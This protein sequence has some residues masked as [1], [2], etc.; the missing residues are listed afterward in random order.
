[1][2]MVAPKREPAA[3]VAIAHGDPLRSRPASM[4]GLASALLKS[5]EALPSGRFVFHRSGDGTLSVAFSQMLAQARTILGGL[6]TPGLR[7]GDAIVL[8][9][10]RTE[11]FIPSLW[12][13][14]LGGLVAVPFGPRGLEPLSRS[15]WTGDVGAI[16]SSAR[17]TANSHPRPGRHNRHRDRP[18]AGLAHIRH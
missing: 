13:A 11:D 1:M 6:N 7:P 10:D 16:R 17:R 12:A 18:G 3:Q 15:D 8:H 9:F 2:S 5:V 4:S 14:F